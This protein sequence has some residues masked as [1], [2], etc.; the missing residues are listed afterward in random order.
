M[1]TAIKKEQRAMQQKRQQQ[2]EQERQVRETVVLCS[3]AWER[4]R[5]VYHVKDGTGMR[6]GLCIGAVSSMGYATAAATGPARGCRVFISAN[7][8]SGVYIITV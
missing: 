1:A 7:G 5:Q 4:E 6:L 3:S 8:V 2:S